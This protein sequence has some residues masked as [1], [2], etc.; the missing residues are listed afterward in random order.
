M[1]S[2]INDE[3]F[4]VLLKH[5]VHEY[6]EDYMASLPSEEEMA[7]LYPISPEFDKKMLRLC[8]KLERERL[9]KRLPVMLKKAAAFFLVFV[10]VIS[11]ALILS[12]TVRASV[13]EVITQVFSQYTQYEY[14]ADS[15]SIKSKQFELAYIPG[16][17]QLIK[18][19]FG[20]DETTVYR[21]Y[22]NE[23]GELLYFDSFK[24]DTSMTTYV[25]NEHSVYSQI[26]FNGIKADLYEAN[27]SG[28]PSSVLWIEDGYS[29]NIT[30]YLQKDEL[31]KM[32]KSLKEKNN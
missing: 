17:Y 32:A 11:S 27:V 21:K 20:I 23:R 5:A 25:D 18:T 26:E 9:Y 8:A 3:L 22:E 13:K 15:K 2:E 7:R 29:F 28:S 6:W 12:P 4:E 30:G 31:I 16:G 10:G 19:D 1:N 14:T 24:A